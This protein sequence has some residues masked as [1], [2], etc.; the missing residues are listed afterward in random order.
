MGF[1]DIFFIFVNKISA[2]DKQLSTYNWCILQWAFTIYI[3]EYGNIWQE[4]IS[5][6]LKLF[7][8]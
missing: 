8:L 7:F 3:N 4:L 2:R 5:P 1:G 6:S